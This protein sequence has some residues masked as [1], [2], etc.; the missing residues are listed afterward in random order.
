MDI[1]KKFLETTIKLENHYYDF[2]K[3]IYH[4]DA[5]IFLKNAIEFNKNIQNHNFH[6]FYSGT[7]NMRLYTGKC[8]IGTNN[9]LKSFG[10]INKISSNELCNLTIQVI[11]I[12]DYVFDI[13]PKL[14]FE[15]IVFRSLSLPIDDLLLKLKEGDYY[16]ELGINCTTLTPFYIIRRTGGTTTNLNNVFLT[17]ILPKDTKCYYMNIPFT[18]KNNKN[19]T[20]EY[21]YNEFELVLPRDCIYL[22]KSKKELNNQYFFTLELLY[23]VPPKDRPIEGINEILPTRNPKKIEVKYEKK[24]CKMD[25]CKW[26]IRLYRELYENQKS[27]LDKKPVKYIDS[28]KFWIYI[29]PIHDKN[30]IKLQKNIKIIIIKNNN[31]ITKKKLVNLPDNL[32]NGS[33]YYYITK[34]KNEQK[35]KFFEINKKSPLLFLIEIDNKKRKKV[36]VKVNKYNNRYDV[37]NITII[38]KNIK[39]EKIID[40]YNYG[41]VKAEIV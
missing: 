11:N 24:T 18:S 15:T 10:N 14:P 26:V 37:C 6:E 41:I 21:Y 31:I 8:I 9:K 29:Y 39:Y 1:I 33:N 40:D 16:R 25:E 38:I 7:I 5:Y 32:S 13:C 17:I 12:L 19:N 3:K 20:K 4:N 22:V 36:K 28:K 30:F 27:D 34:N 23:H 2:W 35:N